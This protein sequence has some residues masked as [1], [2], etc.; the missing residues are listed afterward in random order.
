V[1][2]AANLVPLYGL[3]YWNWSVQGLVVLY[4]FEVLWIGALTVVRMS[5]APQPA[6]PP[7]ERKGFRIPYFAFF[8][9]VV[10]FISGQFFLLRKGQSDAMLFMD[11]LTPLLESVPVIEREGL[12]LALVAICASRT[13][14]L[15]WNYI[16]AGEY[17]RA[18]LGDLMEEAAV[19]AAILF[20]AIFFG[21]LIG[22]EGSAAT[23]ATPVV[24]V[25]LKT[26]L[27]L[28]FH[29]RAHLPNEPG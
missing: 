24:L 9:V 16:R 20:F 10:A 8:Y 5:I 26:V 3:A 15:Y 28:V 1:L 29:L 14:S 21:A 23:L 12:W 17:R 18:R 7:W 11:G 22:G 27:D 19:R 6:S 13:F 4:W 25:I 2:V